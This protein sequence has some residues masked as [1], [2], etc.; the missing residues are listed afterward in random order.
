[1]TSAQQGMRASV[2]IVTLSVPQISETMVFSVAYPSICV[3]ATHGSLGTR[4][5]FMER[6]TAAKTMSA[7][8]TVNNGERLS[9]QSARRDTLMSSVVSA[10]R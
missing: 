3:T 6:G 5:I 9:T 2:S 8:E 4:L 1:M 7:K 10:P